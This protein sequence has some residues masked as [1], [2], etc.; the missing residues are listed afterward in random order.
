MYEIEAA[1]IYRINM[2]KQAW[3]SKEA[4]SVRIELGGFSHGGAQDR[5][6]VVIPKEM[7]TRNVCAVLEVL[8]CGVSLGRSEG[9]ILAAN[10][11]GPTAK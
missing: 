3:C 11:V 1:G 2:K 8:P 4:R 10:V 6:A 5:L 9:G 7:L